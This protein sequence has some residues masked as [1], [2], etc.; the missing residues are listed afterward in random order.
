MILRSNTVLQL[1]L[2]G[3]VSTNELIFAGS[4]RDTLVETADK[5]RSVIHENYFVGQSN[6]ATAVTMLAAPPQSNI[7]RMV[8]ELTISNVD[9]VAATITVRLFIDPSMFLK[10]KITLDPGD[11]ICYGNDFRWYVLDSTGALKGAG[12]AGGGGGGAQLIDDLG[13][14]SGSAAASI[15]CVEGAN[16][17]TLYYKIDF[18]INVQP[19]TDTANIWMRVDAGSGFIST[20]TP[21]RYALEGLNEIAS[22]SD[23]SS[24]SADQILIQQ[25][26][27]TAAGEGFTG[28]VLMHDPAKDHSDGWQVFR[29]E[30]EAGNA[31]TFFNFRAGFGL[32]EGSTRVVGVQILASTGNVTGDVYVRGYRK[33]AA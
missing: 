8:H 26:V 4:Y 9:T 27:G 7:E 16:N 24:S 12:G 10:Q 3:A 5:V 2:A 1:L 17:W 25:N 32:W 30:T 28:Q 13:K 21:Y 18:H 6:G 14:F 29:I 33:A 22:A 31:S 15:D 20:G 11:T 19:D 23:I